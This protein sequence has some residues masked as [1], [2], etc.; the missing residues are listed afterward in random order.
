M[1]STSVTS[2]LTALIVGAGLVMALVLVSVPAF[3]GAATYAYVDA[4]GDVKM[5]TAND[6]QTAISV[7]P[8]R[9]MNSGVLLLN[10]AS[11]F[12]I[13]GDSVPGY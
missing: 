8:N 3:A 11:D 2:N 13:V 1:K 6:W 7:A 5:V 9:H 4:Q 12:T 10:S